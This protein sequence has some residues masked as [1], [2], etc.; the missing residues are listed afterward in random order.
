MATKATNA[1]AKAFKALHVPGTPLRLANIHDATSARI[2]GTLPA[3]R[4]IATS[5]AG[6]A[7]SIGTTDEDLTLTEHLAALKPIA[8]VARSLGKPLTVDLQEGYG[9]Q[10]E[11]AI[12]GIIELGAVGA[13]IEDS[14]RDGQSV[15]PAE[16]AVQ[17]IKRALLAASDEG[18]PDFVVNARSDAWFRGGTLEESIRRGEQFLEAGATA[19]YVLTSKGYSAEDVKAM[20]DAFGGMLNL[21]FKV[22]G[23]PAPN[24][25][26]V[27]QLSE[28]RVTRLSVGPQLYHVSAKVLVEAA[29]RVQGPA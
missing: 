17:R 16:T 23:P 13:N 7:L 3:T 14:A 6:I 28:L 10:L 15:M 24:A 2:I 8:G 25:L 4:A 12:R 21:G 29:A 1:A 18:V 20:V 9:E 5:S 11:E 27:Q 26:D 22:A 19:V